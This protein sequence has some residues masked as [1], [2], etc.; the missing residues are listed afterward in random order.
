MWLILD[1]SNLVYDPTSFLPKHP[2]AAGFL[3]EVAGEDATNKFEAAIHSQDARD[4]A[5]ELLIRNSI[6][7]PANSRDC[8]C[9][10]RSDNSCIGRPMNS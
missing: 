7:T 5:K 10:T 3:L 9:H 2:G 8:H 6:P 1:G 4:K